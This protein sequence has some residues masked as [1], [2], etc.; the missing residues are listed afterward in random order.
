MIYLPYISDD[1]LESAVQSVVNCIFQVQAE[2]SDIY[3]NVIY[4]FSAI[5]DGVVNRI[6]L[7]DLLLKE[8]VRQEQKT[9]QN[10]IGEF[11]QKILGSIPGWQN[12]GTGQLIDVCN[13]ITKIIAYIKN[14]HNTVKGSDRTS[15]YENLLYAMPTPTYQDFTAYYVEI[16][17]KKARKNLIYNRPFTRIYN[18]TKKRRYPNLKRLIINRKKFYYRSLSMLFEIL[19]DAISKVAGVNQLSQAEKERFRTLFDRAY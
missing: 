8:T 19:P 14:K 17:P 5:F 13:P 16:I 10:A 6:I 9:V 12:L 2:R 7:D 1:D 18:N 3:R 15:I 11:H 4:P